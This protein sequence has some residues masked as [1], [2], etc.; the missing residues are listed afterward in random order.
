MNLNFQM[1]SLLSGFAATLCLGSLFAQ[2]TEKITYDD[3]VFP[4]LESKCLN[5]HNPDKKKGDLDLSTYIGTMAG[6]SG[7]KIALAGDG[8]SSKLYTV[9][10]HTEEPVM[11]PEGDK[12]AKKD[13]D[14]IRAW[15]DGGLLENKGSKAQKKK[16]PAFSLAAVPA[17]NKRPEG[18]PPMPK[19]LLLEPVMVPSRSTVIND[20]DASPW[21]PLIAVTGQRQVL[22]YNTDTLSLAAVLPFPKGQ[23]ETVS[24]HPSGKYIL[25]G[26]GIGGKSGS[27][28]VWDVV[29]GKV[30]MEAGKEFDSVMA[31]DLR[32]D[33]GGIALG[34]PSRLIKLW[35]TQAGE[36]IKSI[37]KHTDWLIS[38]AYSYDGI[39]L[40]TGDR[41]NGLQVW[42]AATGNEFHS[43][44]GHQ[45]SIVDVKWR[46]DSN[47]LATAS[48][49]GQVIFWDMNS[50]N[51]IK[52]AAAHGS[53]VLAMDYALSGDI[54]TSGRDRKVKLWKPDLVLKKELPAFAEMITEVA[55]SH[56][57][58]RVFVAD[59]N[60][61]IQVWDTTTYQ[62]VGTLNPNPPQIAG[63][64]VSLQ[65]DK[66]KHVAI[67]K[68]ESDKASGVQ[69]AFDAAKADL[70]K[71]TAAVAATKKTLETLTKEHDA[72]TAKWN[73]LNLAHQNKINELKSVESQA[74]AA[75]TQLKQLAGEQQTIIT[76]Q[77][78]IR[79]QK[80]KTQQELAAAEKTTQVARDTLTK[81]PDDPQLK[82]K[83]AQ[84][85]ATEHSK[86]QQVQ[87]LGPK[88]ANLDKRVAE[89]T[90][91]LQDQQAA[92]RASSDKTNKL[93]AECTQLIAQRDEVAK[94][95]DERNKAYIALKEKVPAMEKVIKPAADLV[96]TKDKLW[97]DSQAKLAA[98]QARQKHFNQQLGFWKSAQI[99]TKVLKAKAKTDK[100]RSDLAD[101]EAEEKELTKQY[102]ESQKASQ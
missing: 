90:K 5:C 56:D 24:F 67:L 96:I 30:M 26:G 61:Q 88:L 41:N 86:R 4:V 43:L 69:E 74:V 70:A 44:R 92:A 21:A 55:F 81:K 25:A 42:E 49:D 77:Q 60:G 78:Q 98:E 66:E 16:K 82:Q 62:Q 47:L 79:A 63:R 29:T 91:A 23:P 89:H 64:L 7:G 40:A 100:I 34:G 20:M 68:A 14:M 36:Q 50:G 22:L 57:A 83:L 99:N 101:A 28:K 9:T 97:K 48:E 33:L 37:K 94:V 52:K 18:P 10:V 102:Q 6:S 15:I 8:G 2:T 1:K 46:V 95:K 75:Q 87:Q 76:E 85:E 80:Q 51:Q 39:L 73:E 35:D 71:K 27:T 12:I 19:D 13:A 53:G 54:V 31:A 93:Q 58:K 84:A 32:A 72:F 65:I 11:P 45:K 3:H 38:L 59:W 17:S